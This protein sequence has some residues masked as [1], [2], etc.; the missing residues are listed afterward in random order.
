MANY[1]CDH[2]IAGDVTEVDASDIPTHDMLLAD[3]PCQPSSIARVSKQMRSTGPM[4]FA[5]TPRA[6]SFSM[7]RASS[8]ITTQ[9]HSC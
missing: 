1:R 6:H 2:A 9:G 5:A 4:A 3:F 7:S 8:N